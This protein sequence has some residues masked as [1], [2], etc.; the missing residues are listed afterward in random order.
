LIEYLD[1]GKEEGYFTPELKVPPHDG[2]FNI[3]YVLIESEAGE[4]LWKDPDYKIDDEPKLASED[5]NPYEIIKKITDRVQFIDTIKS[6]GSLLE[7]GRDEFRDD[8]EIV[9]GAMK[10]EGDG[11]VLMFAS[12][13]LKADREMAI[14]A[15]ENGG[16]VLEYLSKELKADREV[17]FKSIKAHGSDLQYANP[18]LCDDKELILIAVEQDGTMLE[19]AS[20][21]I[22]A[23][24]EVALLSVKE[25]GWALAFVSEDLK[26]DQEILSE[27]SDDIKNTLI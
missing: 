27:V 7:Y 20:D 25:N 15:A 18:S 17:V 4:R 8:K 6:D 10:E 13:T 1:V 2:A 22:K 19:Y 23:N 14:A 9:L 3:E 12:D 21:S 24:K 5:D 11:Y 26:K 16:G